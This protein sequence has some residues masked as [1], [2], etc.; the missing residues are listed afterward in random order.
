MGARIIMYII[1][2]LLAA[3]AV[4][5]ISVILLILFAVKDD[6]EDTEIENFNNKSE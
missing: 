6:A 1:L 2:L 5:G 3:F 4:V